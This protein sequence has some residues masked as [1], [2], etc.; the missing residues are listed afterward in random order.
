MKNEMEQKFRCGIWKMS[1]W[2][3]MEDFK[4]GMEDNLSYFHSNSIL[5][6]LYGIYK[7]YTDNDQ[8]YFPQSIQHPFYHL[9]INRGT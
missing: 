4:N 2:N 1:E 7:V 3:G 8:Q 5:D 9:S 6:L